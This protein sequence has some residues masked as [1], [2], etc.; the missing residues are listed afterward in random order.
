MREWQNEKYSVYQKTTVKLLSS[1]SFRKLHKVMIKICKDRIEGRVNS[2]IKRLI[3]FTVLPSAV[4]YGV[5][6]NRDFL[7]GIQLGAGDILFPAISKAVGSNDP[8]AFGRN[9]FAAGDF[10]EDISAVNQV[11][12]VHGLL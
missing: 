5:E 12:G 10:T 8:A 7:R 1:L 3:G 2:L 9:L 6:R 11:A 4:G